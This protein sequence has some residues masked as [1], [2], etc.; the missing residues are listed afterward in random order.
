MGRH[1]SR[2]VEIHPRHPVLAR[3]FRRASWTSWFESKRP[4]FVGSPPDADDLLSK[5]N[6]RIRRES[7]RD[8]LCDC[9]VFEAAT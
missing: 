6:D 3:C 4:E 2:A 9:R 7:G 5:P 8:I 1:V